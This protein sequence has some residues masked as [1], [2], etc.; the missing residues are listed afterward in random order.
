MAVYSLVHCRSDATQQGLHQ[1]SLGKTQIAVLILLLLLCAVCPDN[2]LF[3]LSALFE[4]H[5]LSPR[6]PY[7]ISSH[8]QLTSLK[9]GIWE[10]PT[11]NMRD[12]I[13]SHS[14]CLFSVVFFPFKAD[15]SCNVTQFLRFP[16]SNEFIKETIQKCTYPPPL[17]PIVPQRYFIV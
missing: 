1:S 13:T 14:V 5:L 7:P 9:L 2:C 8:F 17:L 16:F 12:A 11:T 4:L 10:I 6:N 3:Y 15:L